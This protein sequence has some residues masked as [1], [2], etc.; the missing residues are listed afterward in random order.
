M[1]EIAV[2]ENKV[3]EMNKREAMAKT[4][5]GMLQMENDMIVIF[6][7]INAYGYKLPSADERL[8]AKLWAS[9]LKDY[10]VMYGTG[11]IKQAV[12]NFAENDTREY[13]QCP[14]VADIIAE[15]KKIGVNPKVALAK[16]KAEQELQELEK[17][18]REEMDKR[19]EELPEERKAQ[20]EKDIEAIQSGEKSIEAV[21]EGLYG[22]Q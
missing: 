8:M 1:Y 10:I 4:Q 6:G 21:L 15:A 14:T 22:R 19:W 20:I 16:A 12:M 18:H 11:V 9:S 7:A 13:K 17:K 3:A 5:E 2:I